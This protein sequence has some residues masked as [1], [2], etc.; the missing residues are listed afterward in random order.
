MPG[1]DI[2]V[3][4]DD[5]I[6]E[7]S[8]YFSKVLDQMLN[9]WQTND[10]VK[11]AYVAVSGLGYYELSMNGAKVGNRFLAPG[12]TNY[13]KTCLYNMCEVAEQVQEGENTIGALLGTGFYNVNDEHYIKS[14]YLHL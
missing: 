8:D 10:K 3:G 12:W 9:L 5:G 2:K 1:I 6:N 7:D 11:N 4:E 14:P 13:D